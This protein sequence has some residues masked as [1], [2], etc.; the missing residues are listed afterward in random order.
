MSVLPVTYDWEQLRPMALAQLRVEL[1]AARPDRD[2]V[3]Q[4]LQ[5]L[6]QLH[7]LLPAET[8]RS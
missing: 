6:L 2:R 3:A 1:E 4:I 8:M 7:E 5:A